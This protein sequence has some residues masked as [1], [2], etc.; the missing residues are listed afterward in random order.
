MRFL[1]SNSKHFLAIFASD[2][3]QV[4]L[5]QVFYLKTSADHYVRAR[6]ELAKQNLRTKKFIKEIAYYII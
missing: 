6:R 1:L 5:V 4:F 2:L 3:F